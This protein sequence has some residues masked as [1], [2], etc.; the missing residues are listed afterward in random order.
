MPYLARR[1][2]AVL[3]ARFKGAGGRMTAP[4]N[5][6]ATV[7]GRLTDAGGEPVRG[8]QGLRRHTRRH[9]RRPTRAGGR[10]THHEPNGRFRVRLPAGPSREVRVAHWHG[11]HE[12]A[13]AFPRAPLESGPAPGREPNERLSQR[14]TA[15]ASTSESPAQPRCTAE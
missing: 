14:Q 12:V 13:E 6:P 11:A 7:I 9:H 10:H 2:G 15:S 5:E 1:P 8:R 4:S 3:R